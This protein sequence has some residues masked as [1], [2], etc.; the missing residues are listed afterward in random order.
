MWF[1]RRLVTTREFSKH[2]GQ[3]N[4]YIVFLAAGR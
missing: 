4:E 3:R 1:N 2:G